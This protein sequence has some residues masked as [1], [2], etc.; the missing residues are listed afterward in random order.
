M[1]KF[2]NNVFNCVYVVNC[3]GTPLCVNESNNTYVQ[4]VGCNK[5]MFSRCALVVDLLGT[6]LCVNESNERAEHTSRAAKEDEE[7]TK[8]FSVVC[9]VESF[10]GTALCL[11]GNTKRAEHTSRGM[12]KRSGR[13]KQ[14]KNMHLLLE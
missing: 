10:L 4:C 6:P 3:L 2:K 8:V 11:N 14:G 7:I 1:H 13:S 5:N 9:S 12:A